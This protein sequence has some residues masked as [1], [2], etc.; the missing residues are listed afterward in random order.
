M[1]PL[2][3]SN[4]NIYKINILNKFL[5]AIILIPNWSFFDD[6]KLNYY[7]SNI[8]FIY[9]SIEFFLPILINEGFSS[10]ASNTFIKSKIDEIFYRNTLDSA[11]KIYFFIIKYQ[12]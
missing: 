3:K 9:R 2:H 5:L 8:S 6:I 12:Q 7:C 1:I 4:S 10:S 11:T